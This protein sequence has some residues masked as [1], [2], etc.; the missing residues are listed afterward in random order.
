MK[1]A[2]ELLAVQDSLAAAGASADASASALLNKKQTLLMALGWAYNGNPEIRT[3]PEPD[4]GKLETYQFEADL[5][6]AVGANY[7]VSDIRRTDKSEFNGTQD[8][9]RQIREKENEVRI[10]MEYLYKDLQ[11]KVLLIKRLHNFHVFCES[12][13][14][15]KDNTARCLLLRFP[16]SKIVKHVDDNDLAELVI[17]LN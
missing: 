17:L 5:E 16:F 2:E 15:D 13:K 8:K 3:I 10:Q 11:Q 4:M 7:E 9:Q 14:L 1:S 6:L 12:K